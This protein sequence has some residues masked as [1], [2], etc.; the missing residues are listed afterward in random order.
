MLLR[1]EVIRYC[2]TFDKVYE[3]YPFKDHTWTCMRIRDTGRIFAWIYE[4]NDHIWVNVKCDPQWRDFWRD[5]FSSVVPAYHMNKEHWNSIILDGTVPVED[6]K[7]MIAESYELCG[8]RK[9]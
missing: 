9:R 5:A 2:M 4:R 3:D 7:R 8:R 6:I 1:Q